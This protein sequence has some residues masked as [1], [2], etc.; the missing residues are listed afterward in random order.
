[1]PALRLGAVSVGNIK[2]VLA[3]KV[4][5][6]RAHA[7][8]ER[9][10]KTAGVPAELYQAYQDLQ[11]MYQS[12]D[13]PKSMPEAADIL[14]KAAA[15]ARHRGQK[16]VAIPGSTDLQWPPGGDFGTTLGY[17]PYMSR[18]KQILALTFPQ[19]PG[20]SQQPAAKPEPQGLNAP[21][22]GRDPLAA[23]REMAANAAAQAGK[24]ATDRPLAEE[25]A[26]VE[27]ERSADDEEP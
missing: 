11:H 7:E 5:E 3:A 27:P 18:W 1:M 8:Q 2:D 16:P 17:A 25:V 26:L 15:I 20:G 13:T 23:L 21:A 14:K 10:A 12:G 22:S 24:R 19:K 6:M 4:A 9:A